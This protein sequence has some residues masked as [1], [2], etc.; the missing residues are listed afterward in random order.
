MH[1][2]TRAAAAVFFKE[3]AAGRIEMNDHREVDMKVEKDMFP[4]FF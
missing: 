2:R 1:A 3:L 4:S